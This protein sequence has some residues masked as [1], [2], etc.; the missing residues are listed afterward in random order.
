MY[1]L[2]HIPNHHNRLLQLLQ[3][4]V[5]LPSL[6]TTKLVHALTITMGSVPNQ[7][8]FPYNNI[9]SLYA[10]LGELSFARKLFDKMP[11]RNVI[12]YNT[13]IGAYSKDGD[14]REA[15]NL[16]SEMMG[17]G[18]RPTQFSLSGLLSC[19]AL[20]LYRGVQLQALVIKNGLFYAEAFVGTALLGLF[21]RHDHVEEAILAFEDMPCKSLVTWNSMLSILGHHGFVEHCVVLFRELM[22]VESALSECSFVGVLSGFSCEHDLDYG[23]QI[24]GLVIK[25]GFDY[26]ASVVNCLINMYVKC[27]DIF[28]A[29]RTFKTMPICDVVSWNTIIGAVAN[30]ERP[31][32]A[33]ELFLEMCKSGVFPSQSTYASV[34]NS[35]TSLEIPIYGEFIHA[36]TIR[37]ALES[38]V[39]VGS[40]LI[41]F[42]AKCD[43]LESACRCFDE[44]YQ[45]N[46]VSWNAL[47]LG[48]SNKGS[49]TSMVF[50]QDM[51]RL[52]YQPNEFSFTAVLRL[53]IALELRQLHGLIIRM[54]YQNNEYVSSYLITSY[55]KNDII[56][57]ALVFVTASNDPLPVVPSNIIAGIYNRNGQY[58]ETVKLLSLLEEPDIVSWNIVIAACARNNDYKVVFELFKHMH[59][60]YMHLDGYTFVSLLSVCANIC[61]LALGSSVHALMTKRNFNCRDTFVCNVLINMY[62]K[63][64]CVE[65]SVKI[66]DKMTNKNLITW[67]ALI[68]AFGLNGYAQE[69]LER[70]R[71]MEFLR[72]KPDRMALLAVLTACRHGG[73]VREGM[74]LFG[75][76]RNYGVEPEM[77]HYHCMVDLL[78]KHGHVR[79]AEKMILSMPFLPN[80][81]IWRSFLEGCKRQE[82]AKDQTMGHVNYDQL[83]NTY[84]GELK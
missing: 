40:A 51:L 6:S 24:H 58:N 44:I 1:F 43:K 15:W 25:N 8:I 68:S 29:E 73:L 69:A 77:D 64:G 27:T 59:M 14:V 12:S 38:D 56:S 66:F 47:I 62:G 5:A 31:R 80:A 7:P 61:N 30:Y 72:F 18:F 71:E 48:Y 37:S 83:N 54:G 17:C 46:V 70:F 34:I 32:K 11:H 52:G 33:L 55:I 35:C 60:V 45:K 74:E 19:G 36:K 50:L 28:S 3:A 49:S 2:G 63:C 76:M 4:C 23:E 67:T 26:E 16:F 79:E 57:D 53:S 10:T 9:V 84:P 42:Y 20:D 65:S 78:A 41:D 75:Q 21:G 82:I 81:I 22:M 13:I 39:Y